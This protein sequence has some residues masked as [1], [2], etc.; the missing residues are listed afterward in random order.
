M[1]F[2]NVSNLQI[3]GPAGGW[4]TW[5]H[6]IRRMKDGDVDEEWAA[7]AAADIQEGDDSA[8]RNQVRTIHISSLERYHQ[9]AFITIAF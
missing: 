8:I 2:S 6:K 5:R 1:A 7:Q 4:K 9:S 3:R